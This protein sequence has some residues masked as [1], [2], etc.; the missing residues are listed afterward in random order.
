MITTVKSLLS[1]GLVALWERHPDHPDGEVFIN[2]P[3]REYLVALT[4]TVREAI[5]RGKLAEVVKTPTPEPAAEV[6]T[7]KKGK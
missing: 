2:D 6:D 3:N 5:N 4:S 1:R 7:K